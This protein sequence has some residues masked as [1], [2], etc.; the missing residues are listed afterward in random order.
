MKKLLASLIIFIFI[1]TTFAQSILKEGFEG[2]SFPP[3]GWNV[4][5]ELGGGWFRTTLNASSI[6]RFTGG[7]VM[8]NS[9]IGVAMCTSDT[10]GR[11]QGLISKMIT[12][13][14]VTDSLVY[15]YYNPNSS[16]DSLL[17]C[18]STTNN[19]STTA[20]YSQKLKIHTGWMAK[21]TRSAISLKDYVGIPI[22][23]GFFSYVKNNLYGGSWFLDDIS[24]GPAPQYDLVTSNKLVYNTAE[25]NKPLT[26]ANIVKNCGSAAI[27]SAEV[28][29]KIDTLPAVISTTFPV[30]T[31]GNSSIIQSNTNFIPTSTGTYS[32]KFWVSKPNGGIDAY[33]TDDTV[34]GVM[35]VASQS[36]HKTPLFEEFTS[37]T[38][39]P[40]ASFNSGVFYPFTTSASDSM[41][42]IKYQQDFPG[43]G[44]PYSNSFAVA[45]RNYY[46]LN[47]IPTVCAQGQQAV[48]SS[49]DAATI[50]NLQHYISMAN[51]EIGEFDISATPTYS[52]KKIK[53]PITINPY[54]TR[55]KLTLQVVVCEKMTT[56]NTG[57]NGETKFYHVEMAMA[58]NANG[59]KINFTDGIPYINTF[60]LDMTST[61]VEQM[62]DL[63]V[64][65]FI[66]DDSTKE[67]LQSITADINLELPDVAGTITSASHLH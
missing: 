33:A 23:I 48:W 54:L 7:P 65:A 50:S 12:P 16:Y 39:T 18:V 57:T 26:I 62:S 3:S 60:N 47:S 28:G 63:A 42:F 40:C 11:K 66:Q 58:P 36:V 45:R 25:I 34:F 6:P 61:H 14:S 15:W 10:A 56:G 53:I 8:T 59:T 19:T 1:Q 38:A 24:V 32:F 67:I 46:N 5:T 29:Y 22:Y 51:L 9:G 31:T 41:N 52:G 4:I 37:S 49:S 13:T 2:A 21:Y 27:T 55:S 64:V 17:V 44:D 35:Y 20:F 43:S 30:I